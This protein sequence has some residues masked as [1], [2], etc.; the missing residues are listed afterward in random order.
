VSAS[1]GLDYFKDTIGIASTNTA[2]DSRL[3]IYLDA[4]WAGFINEVGRDIIQTTYPAAPDVGR[5]DNGIYSGGG[6]R[7]ILL[8]QRPA[9]T[10]GMEVYL[11][12]SGRFGQNPDGS[13]ATATK[14]TYGTDYC[15]RTDG[16]LPGTSTVC[17]YSGIL[18]RVGTNWPG[19]A[20]YTPGQV[21]L[22]PTDGGGNI[23]VIYTGGWPTIPYDIRSCVCQIAA[24]IR[25][26]ADKGGSMTSESLGGYSYSLGAQVAA[27]AVPEMGSI[28]K[29]V[30]DYKGV[31]L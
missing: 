13:F 14:L 27:G 6:Y 7:Q 4:A 15:L 26:N 24:Y 3:Q 20:K 9:I 19:R 29:T 30:L 11:D 25:R 1:I 2:Q 17:S 16:C 5:G 21:T 18:E 8:R 31:R 10:T 22:Q 23:K 12:S 28:R